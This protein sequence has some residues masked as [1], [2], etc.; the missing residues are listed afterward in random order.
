MAS[1]AVLAVLGCLL[2]MALVYVVVAGTHRLVIKLNKDRLGEVA[3]PRAQAQAAKPSP[4]WAGSAST[5][6]RAG[7]EPAR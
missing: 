2:S 3:M 1:R 5:H 6:P 7:V 4:P